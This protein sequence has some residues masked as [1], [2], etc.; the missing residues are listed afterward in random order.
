M[1][2]ASEAIGPRGEQLLVDIDPG[3]R[4]P[5]TNSSGEDV[6]YDRV[7][8]W[9]ALVASR[10]GDAANAALRS[11]DSYH[12]DPSDI[13]YFRPPDVYLE[14]FM[15]PDTAFMLNFLTETAVNALSPGFNAHFYFTTLVKYWNLYRINFDWTMNPADTQSHAY[16]FGGL[17]DHELSN[18]LTS[19]Q[20]NIDAIDL[21]LPNYTTE[22][23]ISKIDS[24]LTVLRVVQK[25]ERNWQQRFSLNLLPSTF[26]GFYTSVL[27]IDYDPYDGK[28]DAEPLVNGAM[29]FLIRTIIDNA[30]KESRGEQVTLSI[31]ED[32]EYVY[33][34][35]YD[36]GS[37]KWPEQIHSDNDL[38][39]DIGRVSPNS[40]MLFGRSGTKMM[41]YYLGQRLLPKPELID[42]GNDPKCYRIKIPREITTEVN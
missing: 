30:A 1:V 32:F 8:F 5:I 27:K 23:L 31:W 41:S 12:P 24:L 22:K 3:S 33:C 19:I 34:D 40:P 18:M 16:E 21:G 36:S 6:L 10:G 13:V 42:A 17:L 7:A 26:D 39:Y 38:I 25:I 14:V 28:A 4:L 29:F 9:L 15:L 2:T 20:S 11:I 35:I 37:E